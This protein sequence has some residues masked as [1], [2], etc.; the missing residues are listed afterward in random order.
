MLNLGCFL[1]LLSQH[2][3]LLIRFDLLVNFL[4]GTHLLSQLLARH[5]NHRLNDL[6]QPHFRLSIPDLSE[7]LQDMLGWL[8]SSSDARQIF[9]H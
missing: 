9:Y 7:L 3:T 4:L 1:S 8:C 2:S 6:G 5:F